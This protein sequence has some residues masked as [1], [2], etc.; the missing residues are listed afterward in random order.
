MITRQLTV[1]DDARHEPP[2]GEGEVLGIRRCNS[3]YL[4]RT[5]YRTVH[6]HGARLHEALLAASQYLKRLEEDLGRP[7]HI[8]CV[9]DE[10]SDADDGTDLTWQ[11][12][13]I[14]GEPYQV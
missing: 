7:P 4:D 11:F 14:L 5:R 9:H 1:T 12:T 13:V 8:L 6:F 2:T 10:F 3:G